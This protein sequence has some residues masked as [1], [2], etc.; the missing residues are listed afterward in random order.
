MG[1]DGFWVGF[2]GFRWVLM[3]FGWVLVDFG[4]MFIVFV[5][6]DVQ[7]SLSR[8]GFVHNFIFG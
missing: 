6:I 2:G 8:R 5:S 4:G 3:G 1:S 7:K